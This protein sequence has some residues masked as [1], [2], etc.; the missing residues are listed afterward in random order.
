MNIPTFMPDEKP[1]LVGKTLEVKYRMNWL[2]DSDELKIEQ[3]TITKDMIIEEEPKPEIEYVKADE[4]GLAEGFKIVDGQKVVKTA[5]QST[6]IYQPPYT[7]TQ[8]GG[9]LVSPKELSVR[10][11]YYADTFVAIKTERVNHKGV[12]EITQF[13]SSKPLENYE[14]PRKVRF[15][16]ET[17]K[18][19][20]FFENKPFPLGHYNKIY[21]YGSEDYLIT[22]ITNHK[23]DDLIVGAFENA[24][25]SSIDIK[26]DK[27]DLN[28]DTDSKLGLDFGENAFKGSSISKIG[29]DNG[30]YINYL[31]ASSIGNYAF[32]NTLNLEQISIN[33]STSLGYFMSN[34]TGMG[35]IAKTAFEGAKNLSRIDVFPDQNFPDQNTYK[36]I[37]FTPYGTQFEGVLYKKEV[38][39]PTEKNYYIWPE[40]KPKP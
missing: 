17:G 22:G 9:D 2:I 23:E 36:Y 33:R 21:S 10:L 15:E 37:W 7:H 34:V 12:G 35:I 29:Y 28:P 39:E 5:L 19:E 40:G 38:A 6:L 3:V 13:N 32:A 20:V 4:N 16:D 1:T 27:F 18:G 24:F 30:T 14:V 26:W 31:I 8:V 11:D 25:V